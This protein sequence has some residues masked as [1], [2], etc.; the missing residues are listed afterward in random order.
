MATHK[1]IA[2][3]TGGSRGLG[4]DM[5][6]NIAKKGL[7]VILTYNTQKDEALAVVAKIEKTG[8]KAAALQLNTGVVKNFDAFINQLK[9]TLKKLDNAGG[10]DF[11][12]NNAG[13]GTHAEFVDTTEEQ[14][15]ALVNIH[16][17]GAYF[18]TQKT[19]PLLND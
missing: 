9:E 11:L 15:D 10:L 3:V 13:V 16:F 2:L 18:L 14:F 6:L 19:L 17:K 12:V 5:A 7:D 1:K 8:Q 4:K